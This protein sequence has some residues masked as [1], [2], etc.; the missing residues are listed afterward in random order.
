MVSA[1]QSRLNWDLSTGYDFFLSQVAIYEPER[2]G[3]RA[4][5]AAG[6]R[7]R[8]SVEDRQTLETFWQIY[9]LPMHFIFSVDAPKDTA[10]ILKAIEHLP[11]A[12]RLD[13][14]TISYETP[15]DVKEILSASSPRAKW[16]QAERDVIGEYYANHRREMTPTLLDMVYNSW[17][18]REEFGQKHLSALKAY[19][20]SFF[21]EE[22]HR[23]LPA[24]Q[25]GLSH[26]Q[27]RAGTLP[28]P[29]MLE[30]LSSGVRWA[31]ITAA[32]KIYLAPSFWGAPFLFTEHLDS[33]TIL[34]VFGSRPDDMALIP[35]DIVPDNLLR[36]LKALADPTRL[37][38]LRTLAQAP[39]S[40][41]HLSRVLRL[42]PPTVNHHLMELRMAGMV[43][44]II[45]A[46]GDRYYATRFEGFE[47]TYEQL[48]RFVSE[49]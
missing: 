14:L 10:T 2:F 15:A 20:D 36:G 29:A 42:R 9:F 23:I 3:L 17:A 11:A 12:K 33:S 21:F 31:E 7:S 45:S 30:E 47:S 1:V 49:E 44:V 43:H 24:L 39:Q 40:A 6:V 27:M 22:E 41:A 38:I 4:S 19:A 25:K 5:W 26:A 46:E 18:H 16:T 13:A 28:L 48:T 8:L 37:R 34:V 35:G 32:R